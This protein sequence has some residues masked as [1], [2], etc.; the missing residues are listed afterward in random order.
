MEHNAS[1]SEPESSALP[2][3]R[4]GDPEH[5]NRPSLT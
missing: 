4:V 5:P 3:G 2:P 1:A